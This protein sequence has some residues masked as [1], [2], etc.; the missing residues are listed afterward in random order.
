ML[1]EARR[2][3][4]SSARSSR[5]SSSAKARESAADRLQRGDCRLSKTVTTTF[6]ETIPEEPRSSIWTGKQHL[7]QERCLRVDDVNDDRQHGFD[8][9][10]NNADNSCRD[11]GDVD[12]RRW[13]VDH[14][15]NVDR[16]ADWHVRYETPTCKVLKAEASYRDPPGLQTPNKLAARQA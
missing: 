1:S 10:G 14:T 5:S 15:Q 13:A 9:T 7:R 6:A 3:A 16:N 11:K 2:L 12:Q 8:E 4:N